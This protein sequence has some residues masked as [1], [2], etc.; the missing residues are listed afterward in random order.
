MAI[1]LPGLPM[2]VS[3]LNR[4]A[5]SFHLAEYPDCNFVDAVLNIINVGASIGHSGPQKPQSCNN[6]RVAVDHSPIISKEI[7]YLLSDGHIH[8]PL[9]S[10]C[11]Q[12]S[13]AHPWECLC[14]SA[15]LSVMFLTITPG[16]KA[17]QSTLRPKGQSITIHLHPQKPLYMIQERDHCWPN[18]TLKMHTG[19]SQST[20][21]IGSC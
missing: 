21:Q 17:S 4:D 18:W 20:V 16:T 9:W 3:P 14:A 13:T 5:W 7:Y 15:T 19:T 11:S 10:H 2:V 8:G 1:C 12:I 6:L